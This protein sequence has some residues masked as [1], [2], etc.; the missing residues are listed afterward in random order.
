[1][2]NYD[3]TG[4][5]APALGLLIKICTNVETWL[6]ESP[7]NIAILHCY[8][9]IL[10]L[11]SLVGRQGPHDAPLRLHSHLDGLVQLAPGGLSALPEPSRT[12]GERHVSL[13]APLSAV[14]RESSAERSAL[15][16]RAAADLP[17]RLR[18]PRRRERILRPLPRSRRVSTFPRRSTTRTSS[19]IPVW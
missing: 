11:I 4:Y 2:V 9:P 17:H 6:S 13:P 5:P 8:V 18:A 19:S 3:F 1:M 14:L 12:L 7:E 15:R 10:P 16:R